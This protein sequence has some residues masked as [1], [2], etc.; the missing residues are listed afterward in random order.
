MTAA[1]AESVEF[2]PVGGNGKAVLGRDFLLETFD[3]A[4]FELHDLATAGTDEVIVVALMGHV[5][6]LGLC[7][8][9]SRLSESCFAKEVEGPVDGCESKMRILACQLVIHGLSR[10]V[11]LFQKGVEDQFTLA[12]ELELVPP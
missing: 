9:V 5:V 10:D 4:V 3:V 2:E 11:F 8:K 6:V 12:R 1:G 7:S